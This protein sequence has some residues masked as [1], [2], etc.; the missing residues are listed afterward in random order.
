MVIVVFNWAIFEKVT[1]ISSIVVGVRTEEIK[2]S[3]GVCICVVPETL[4]VI[5]FHRARTDG[6]S[7]WLDKHYIWKTK[8]QR[9][10]F[11]PVGEKRGTRKNLEFCTF[12]CVLTMWR[13][14][15]G[16]WI[17][18]SSCWILSNVLLTYKML[19][20]YWI[21]LFLESL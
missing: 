11:S 14:P 12:N 18:L 3:N 9:N 5:K 19:F 2:N 6:I 10:W 8:S 15:K 4:N 13:N 20:S 7:N 16:H 17:P 1:L 21:I